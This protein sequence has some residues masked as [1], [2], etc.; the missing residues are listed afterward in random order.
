MTRHST[1]APTKGRVFVLETAEEGIGAVVGEGRRR[2]M[3]MVGRRGGGR[4]G[5]R[6]D[7]GGGGAAGMDCGAE[8]ET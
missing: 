2:G 8:L 1:T 5:G 6:E 4:G 3:E 7:D